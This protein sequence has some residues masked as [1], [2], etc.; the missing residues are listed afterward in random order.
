MLDWEVRKRRFFAPF[1]LKR[2]VLP[3]QAR[4]KHR[5]NSKTEWSPRFLAGECQ[6]RILPKIVHRG[7]CIRLLASINWFECPW[8]DGDGGGGGDG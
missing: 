7:E 5:E 6:P 8:L 3:R 1:Y 4:D 2:I